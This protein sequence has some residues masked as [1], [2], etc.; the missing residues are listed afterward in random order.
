MCYSASPVPTRHKMT[1]F[2]FIPAFSCAIII[3]EFCPVVLSA[4]LIFRL[5]WFFKWKGQPLLRLPNFFNPRWGEGLPTFSTPVQ[6]RTSNFL[7]DRV[8]FCCLY[9]TQRIVYFL[10]FTIFLSVELL[11]STSSNSQ[12][13]VS[14]FFRLFFFC[15]FRFRPALQLTHFADPQIP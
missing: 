3:S 1:G 6:A 8:Y 5:F 14:L 4:D 15:L 7:A 13:S 12:N 9:Y 10:F 2:H 11:I